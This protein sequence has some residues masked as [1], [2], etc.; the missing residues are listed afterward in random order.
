VA[1]ASVVALMIGSAGRSDGGPL[2]GDDVLREVRGLNP[3]GMWYSV[4]CNL[5]NG[6]DNTCA[7]PSQPSCFECEYPMT[8][9][10]RFVSAG[11]GGF[12]GLRTQ[13]SKCGV[14]KVGQCY[15][16]FCS[17]FMNTNTNCDE[18]WKVTA[19]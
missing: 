4:S 2:L 12:D 18:D 19:Q 7:N 1:L 17:I 14:M 8:T 3:N 15:G 16:T 6:A 9:A 5:M 10:V 11:G 13:T